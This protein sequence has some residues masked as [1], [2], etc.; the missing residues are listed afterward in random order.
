MTEEV[1][2]KNPWDALEKDLSDEVIPGVADQTVITWGL[3]KAVG[4]TLVYR[5]ENGRAYTIKLVGGLANSLFQGNII[6][7]EDAF[8]RKYPSISGFRLFLVDAPFQEREEVFRALDWALRD[9]GVDLVRTE[10][11]LAEF[12]KIE[13]TYLSIFLILGTFGLIFGS[14][15]I[16]IVIGRNVSERRGELALLRAVGFPKAAIRTLLVSEHAVLLG[17]GL[18]I[19]TV[20]AL[21]AVLP[22]L[23]TPGSDIPFRTIIVLLAF[24]IASGGFW[25]YAATVLATKSDLLPSLR[26]E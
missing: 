18:G 21:L 2:R 22:S 9:R 8:V 16:G 6:I 17:A 11:R 19:G 7:S 24:V 25:T 4:D 15:G 20:S 3:G 13:N 12:N 1:N 26:D 23:L 5:D 14:I 10:D